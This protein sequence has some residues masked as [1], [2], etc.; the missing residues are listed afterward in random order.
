MR[1]EFQSRV[2]ATGRLPLLEAAT[3]FAESFRAPPWNEQWSIESASAALTADEK[4]GAIFV[5]AFS[6]SGALIG[7]GVG[8]ALSA[9]ECGR[10]LVQSGKLNAACATQCFYNMDLCVTP[11]W[12]KR[13]V[14]EELVRLRLELARTGGFKYVLTRTRFDNDSMLRL[15]ARSGFREVARQNAVTGGIPSE[16]IVFM[17]E[18]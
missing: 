6:T 16:R 7:L 15:I 8:I 11:E 13:G 1:S 9:S 18:I 5:G 4:S 10:D 3:I 12:R 2:I 17:K 14:G